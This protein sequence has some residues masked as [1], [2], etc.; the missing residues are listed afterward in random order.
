[1]LTSHSSPAMENN[2]DDKNQ[3]NEDDDDEM[4]EII[5][6]DG[7]EQTP[8]TIQSLMMYGNDGDGSKPI[9]DSLMAKYNEN[10]RLTNLKRM[11]YVSNIAHTNHYVT[12]QDGDHDNDFGRRKRAF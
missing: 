11:G 4:K 9:T 5:N 12:I 3:N 10:S 1:M 7:S 8:N 6:S 2:V